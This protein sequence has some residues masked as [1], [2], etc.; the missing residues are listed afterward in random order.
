LSYTV[1]PIG[2]VKKIGN[3]NYLD[4][5]EEYWEATTHLDLFS[6]AIVL[7]WIDGRDTPENRQTVLS[8]PPKNKGPV[9]SGVFSCRSPSRPNPIGHTIV[10][11]INVDE[12]NKQILIDHMDANDG[13]PIIDIK[14]YLPSSDK[15]DN[16]RVAPW[17]EHLENR[18]TQ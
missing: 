7:W 9:P 2:H 10:K 12:E 13:T 5:N 14:P 16:A 6:H 15:V 17:F 8:N 4:I 1:K 18:Y 3:Q 11:I